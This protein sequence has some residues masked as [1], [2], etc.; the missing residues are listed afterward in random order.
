MSGSQ[1]Q[2]I[3]GVTLPLIEPPGGIEG[4]N[5]GSEDAAGIAE[6]ASAEMESAS[7]SSV[8]SELATGSQ[9]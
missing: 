7:G 3:E 1:R 6:D 5:E 2:S 4:V 8:S 9:T